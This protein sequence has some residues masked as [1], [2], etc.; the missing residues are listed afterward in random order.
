[1]G[2]TEEKDG[3]YHVDDRIILFDDFTTASRL[4]DFDFKV[5]SS[6]VKILHVDEKEQFNI[7]YMYYL[8]QTLDIDTDNHQRYWISKLKNQ[9]LRIHTI[10]DQNA[11]VQEINNAVFI[12]DNLI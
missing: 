4:I 8:L 2:Y 11:I 3:I 7:E 5:K 6:A 9:E 10:E 1:M 12:L